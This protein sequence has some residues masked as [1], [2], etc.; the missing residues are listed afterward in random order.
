M[1]SKEDYIPGVKNIGESERRKRYLVGILGF[2]FAILY[3]LIVYF[4][5]W[6]KWATLFSFILFFVGFIGIIQGKLSFCAMFALR[7]TYDVSRK[8]NEKK[9]VEREEDHEKD[10]RRARQIHLYTILFSAV[11]TVLTYIL[12]LYM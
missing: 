9:I 10:L 3:L 6:P 12:F 2:L 4:G 11:A 7:E 1:N 8:G 5:K